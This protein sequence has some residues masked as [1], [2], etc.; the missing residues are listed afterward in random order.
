MKDI[1]NRE[2]FRAQCGVYLSLKERNVNAGRATWTKALIQ[3]TRIGDALVHYAVTVVAN[4]K[5][6]YKTASAAMPSEHLRDKLLTALLHKGYNARD[7]L[8]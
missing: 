8:A 5:A 2:E 1:K 6:D 3:M 4:G 7:L